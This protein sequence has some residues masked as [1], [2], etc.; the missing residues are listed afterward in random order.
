MQGDL[1]LPDGDAVIALSAGLRI[2][3]TPRSTA[4]IEALRCW[5]WG[6]IGGRNG[7]APSRVALRSGQSIERGVEPIQLATPVP[8]WNY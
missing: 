1:L 4:D 6:A 8:A 7:I 5:R 3:R 2:K